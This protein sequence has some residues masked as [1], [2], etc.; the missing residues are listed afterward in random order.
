M[1]DMTKEYKTNEVQ[2]STGINRAEFLS[3]EKSGTL[4][5]SDLYQ[6]LQTVASESSDQLSFVNNLNSIL[7]DRLGSTMEFVISFNGDFWYPSSLNLPRCQLWSGQ[8]GVLI[9]FD[10][11][12]GV[13]VWW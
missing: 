6:V 13:F 12:V 9:G 3:Q 5:G 1:S 4:S 8:A 10:Q 11:A 7:T 2:G